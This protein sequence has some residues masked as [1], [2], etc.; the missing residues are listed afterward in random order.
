MIAA[1][2]SILPVLAGAAGSPALAT[3]S[4]PDVSLWRVVLALVLCLVL[5]GVAA[6]LLRRRMGA[7]PLWP[8]GPAQPGRLQLLERITL[9]PQSSA[10][11]VAVDGRELLIVSGAS[12]I[13]IQVLEPRPVADP[14]P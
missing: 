3:G 11:L 10:A 5:A 4:G 13:A 2:P 6:W 7:D 14:A 9:G 1:L 8:L 12:G